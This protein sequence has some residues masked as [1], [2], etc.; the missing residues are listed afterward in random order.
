MSGPL[1]YGLPIRPP[2]ASTALWAH[3]LKQDTQPSTSLSDTPIVVPPTVPLDKNATSMRVLLHDTQANF[4]KF[5]IHVGKLIDGVNETKHEIKTTNDLF[6]RDRQTLVGDIIDLGMF[7]PLRVDDLSREKRI[8]VNEI[9]VKSFLFSSVNRSQKEIQKSVGSPCQTASTETYFKDVNHRLD[10]LD[11][12]LDAIQAVIT[13]TFNLTLPSFLKFSRSSTRH[14]LRLSRPR[15]KPFK[16]YWINK[17]QSYLPSYLCCRFFR[18][19]RY[20]L[21]LQEMP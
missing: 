2:T 5:A 10:T 1:K 19:S 21:R 20:I 11:Q 9:N 18:Q 16:S 15:S 8:Y 14:I 3:I 12:R 6:E 7:I 17:E 4:E 13:F